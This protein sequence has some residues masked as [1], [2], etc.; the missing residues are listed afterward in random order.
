[1]AS[2]A[3]QMAVGLLVV[4]AVILVG[5]WILRRV[6]PRLGLG[7]SGK[8]GALRLMG[9]MGLGPRKQLLVVRFLN[10]DLLLGVTENSITLLTEVATSHEA[11]TDFADSLARAA[12]SGDSPP[13]S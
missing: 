9:Q 1:M 7:P 13:S 11:D 2:V 12:A 5:Y 6:G 4:L 3:I 10:K 8:G